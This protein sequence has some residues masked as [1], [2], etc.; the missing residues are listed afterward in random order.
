MSLPY[1][2]FPVNEQTIEPFLRTGMSDL[3]AVFDI[4]GSHARAITLS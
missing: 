4:A 2:R 1:S 3:D